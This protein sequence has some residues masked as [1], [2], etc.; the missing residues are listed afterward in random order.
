MRSACCS[1]GRSVA[2]GFTDSASYDAPGI[3]PHAVGVGLG[4]AV[5]DGVEVAVRVA[6]GVAVGVGG[7]ML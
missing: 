6:V 5:G 1:A 3:R 2:G 4:V 7:G